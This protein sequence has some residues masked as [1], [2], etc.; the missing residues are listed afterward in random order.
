MPTHHSHY[1]N[2]KSSYT[3]KGNSRYTDNELINYIKKFYIENG[4]PPSITDFNGNLNYPSHQTFVYRFGTWN[5]VLKLAGFDVD[6]LVKK[7]IMECSYHKGRAFE[8]IVSKSFKKDSSDLSGQNCNSPFD[9]ICPKGYNYDAKSSKLKTSVA[10]GSKGWFFHFRN[11]QINIIEYFILGGFNEDY[12]KLLHIWMIP[13]SFVNG[14]DTV[15]IGQVSINNFKEYE[16]TDRCINLEKLF[17]NFETTK[18]NN[19]N[20]KQNNVIE[21]SKI[22]EKQKSIFDY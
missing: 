19:I 8:M 9:G 22:K 7:G 14:R 12:T 20:I 2:T 10:N 13:L 4:K 17:E 21:S 5:N 16:I 6:T 11:K 3:G 18:D 15:Y 1:K